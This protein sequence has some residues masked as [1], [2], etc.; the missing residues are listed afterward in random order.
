MSG[1]PAASMRSARRWSWLCDPLGCIDDE[2]RN[3]RL[4]DGAKSTNERVILS[5]VVDFGAT[6]HSCGV[7][8][9]NASLVGFDQGVDCIA[10]GAGHVMDDTALFATETVE[11]GALADIGTSDDCDAGHALEIGV[12]HLGRLFVT[13]GCLFFVGDAQLVDDDIEQVA[14]ATT[15]E[16]RNGIRLSQPERQETP[17]VG[18]T[19]IVV[20]LVGDDQNGA[21]GA[22]QPRGDAL[23]VIGGTD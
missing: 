16:C 15:M 11:E 21:A 2:Q 14:R 17:T 19:A 20:R 7:D 22:A 18:F 10:R 13:D 5:G 6:A 4:V 3:I 8:E 12:D 23:V 9:N 1:L